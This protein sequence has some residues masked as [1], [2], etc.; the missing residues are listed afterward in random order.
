M[1][2]TGTDVTLRLAVPQDAQVIADYNVAMAW[3]TEQIRLD[4][5]TVLA[6]VR[7]ALADAG[8]ASYFVA[9]VAGRVGAQLMITHEWS[10]WRNGDIWW[11]QSV[12]VHPDFRR[13]G[14]F[15]LLY[16]HATTLAK[17]QGA[18]GIRLYVEKENESA[19]RTY[20]SLGMEA[21]HYL[22]MEEMF[23]KKG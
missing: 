5:P 12:Y 7:A 18:A 22:V 11:I 8:K 4:P 20:A 10:D 15:R 2:T 3:E 21:T 19:Q 9:E 16:Q 17:E 14:L 23:R 6:G 1:T 13:R